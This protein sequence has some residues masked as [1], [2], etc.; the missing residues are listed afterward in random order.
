MYTAQIHVPELTRAMKTNVVMA[1]V[2]RFFAHGRS[3]SMPA[4]QVDS[5]PTTADMK[6]PSARE[7]TVKYVARYVPG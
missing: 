3:T 2:W 1:L 4:S 5:V 7:R 6:L